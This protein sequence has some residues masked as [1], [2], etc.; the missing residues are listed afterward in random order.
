MPG[1]AV[2]AVL[3]DAWSSDGVSTND[4]GRFVFEH[5]RT[6]THRVTVQIDWLDSMRAPGTND[7]DVQGEL[8]AIAEGQTAEVELVV[9]RR[10][11]II[12]GRVLDGDG[13]PVRD[14]FVDATRISD[15]AASSPAR[16][17]MRMHWGGVVNRC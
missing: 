6:G 7:D 15:S 3:T 16:S 4:D 17:R 12:R 14:A 10:S 9:E 1:V 5:L 2:S 11:G 13:G 8:V